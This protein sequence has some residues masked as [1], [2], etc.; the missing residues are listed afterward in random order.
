[1]RMTSTTQLNSQ[2]SAIGSDASTENPEDLKQIL[3]A[4]SSIEQVELSPEEINQLV[5]FMFTLT[6]DRFAEQ[7]RQQLERQQGLAAKERPFRDE[8]TAMRRK[9]PFE[10]RIRPSQQPPK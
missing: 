8:E 2:N 5:A 6:D 7:N 1:M 10:D 3:D 9:L 4:V